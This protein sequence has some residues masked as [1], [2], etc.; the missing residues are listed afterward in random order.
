MP[1]IKFVHRGNFKRTE[2]FLRGAKQLNI[3][4]ILTKYGE[5]GVRA[6]RD[7]TPQ[8]SGETASAWGYEIAKTK[9]GYSVYWTNSNVND[10]VPIA[11]LIQFGHGTGTGGYVAPTD[12]INPALIPI[13]EDL[14]E[15]AWREVVN[16]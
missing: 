11:I 7:N 6:L 5:A 16:L 14:A 9:D 1:A 8:R 10:G 2:K 13:F 4:D 3:H 12:F 15:A